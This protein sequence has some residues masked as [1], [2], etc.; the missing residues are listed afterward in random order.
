[1]SNKAP[2]LRQK[3]PA[4][5]HKAPALR[6]SAVRKPR[7]CAKNEVFMF[8]SKNQRIFAKRLMFVY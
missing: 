5:R 4:L 8:S 6:R 7:K 3:A 2:A 1:M